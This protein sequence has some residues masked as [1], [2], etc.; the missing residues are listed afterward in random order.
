MMSDIE[1]FIIQLCLNRQIQ[2]QK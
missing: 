1:Y 2:L